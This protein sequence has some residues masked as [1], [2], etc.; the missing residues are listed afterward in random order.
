MKK[1]VE[2]LELKINQTSKKNKIFTN[3][4]WLSVPMAAIGIIAAVVGFV[5]GMMPLAVF[6]CTFAGVDVATMI[7]SLV[8][9]YKNI[10]KLMDLEDEKIE[11]TKDLTEEILKAKQETKSKIVNKY[12]EHKDEK[13]KEETK[14]IS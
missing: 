11:L 12:V 5:K 14:T 6:G 3:L 9:S 1:S 10:S 13:N 2:E 7:T 8:L 4:M